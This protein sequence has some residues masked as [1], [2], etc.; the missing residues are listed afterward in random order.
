[1]DFPK[2]KPP[3]PGDELAEFWAFA[4]ANPD[5]ENVAVRFMRKLIASEDRKFYSMSAIVHRL[6]WHYNV[7]NRTDARFKINDHLAAYYSRYLQMKYPDLLGRF[8]FRKPKS[9][10]PDD[11]AYEGVTW[12]EFQRLKGLKNDDPYEDERSDEYASDEYALAIA[13]VR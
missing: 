12:T 3:S 10:R 11:V 2:Y 1:M 6:R 4:N 8:R 13:E 9:G 5:V 7:D